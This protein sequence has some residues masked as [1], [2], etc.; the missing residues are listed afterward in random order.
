MKHLFSLGQ[1]AWRHD[2]LLPFSY[3]SHLVFQ[4]ILKA[5]PS[6]YIQNPSTYLIPSATSGVRR[7]CHVPEFLA[8]FLNSS[9]CFYPCPLMVS[10][11]TGAW[12]VLFK[13]TRAHIISLLKTLQGFALKQLMGQ[14]NKMW[15]RIYMT[16]IPPSFLLLSLN[17]YR[18]HLS[19]AA[20]ATV[21]FFLFLKHTRHDPTL[22]LSC[23]L[24]HFPGYPLLQISKCLISSNLYSNIAF[25]VY[26]ILFL[27]ILRFIIQYFIV[28]Q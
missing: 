11:N 12:E 9:C 17:S 24:F 13:H 5:S 4:Q 15:N 14:D 2:W 1:K 18:S 23:L 25:S 27:I 21:H 8:Q 6:K 10:S 28:F 16:C 26:P 3:T 22:E 7:H 20:P 19:H